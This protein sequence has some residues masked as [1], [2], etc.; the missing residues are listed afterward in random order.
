MNVPGIE[1]AIPALTDKDIADL[2]AVVE[3]AD[4]VEMSFAREPSDIAQLLDELARLGGRSL[5][6]V[7]KV[8]TRQ[9][10]EHLPQLLLTLMRH[11]RV[12]VMIARGDLAGSVAMNAS[13]NCRRRFC[14][15]AKRRT[16]P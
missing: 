9:A 15:C 16:C 13:P 6:V 14:G 1:L 8:E 12:G 7:L 2:A 5:G 10:F 11:P 4:L 3:L